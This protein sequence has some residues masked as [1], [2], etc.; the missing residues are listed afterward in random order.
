MD[1]LLSLFINLRISADE[2]YY[3]ATSNPPGVTG[4]K[5]DWKTING[6]AIPTR[7]W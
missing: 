7:G 2:G 3:V 4:L 1:P 6:S 5:F